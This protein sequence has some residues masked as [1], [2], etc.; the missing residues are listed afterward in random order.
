[1]KSKSKKVY[2]RVGSFNELSKSE[3]L[4]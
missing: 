1:L 3:T 4:T 2:E